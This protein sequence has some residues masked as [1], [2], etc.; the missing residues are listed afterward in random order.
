[1]DR[2]DRICAVCRTSY[3][4]CNRCQEDKDKPLWYFTFHSDNC[5]EIY[6]VVSAYEDGSITAKEA[7]EKLGKLDLSLLDNFGKSYKEVI[8]KITEEVKSTET[9]KIEKKFLK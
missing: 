3:K 2:K 1:M 4:F 7:D 5:K 6:D 9:A 8:S